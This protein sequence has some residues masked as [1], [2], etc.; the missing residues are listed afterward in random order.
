[1]TD[2]ETNNCTGG[3]SST[4]DLNVIHDVDLS[5][6]STFGFSQNTAHFLE[7]CNEQ[8][9]VKAV[10]L[11]QDRGWPILVVGDGSNIVF[12]HDFPGLI[13]RQTSKYI[14][15]SGESAYGETHVTAS[16]GVNWN[17]LVKDT[18]DRGYVGLENLSLIPGQ[19]GAAPVQNIG[20]YGVELC[21]RMVSLRAFHLPSGCWRTMSPSDCQFSYRNSLFKTQNQDYIIAEV[22]FR[23]GAHLGLQTGYGALANYLEENHPGEQPNAGMVSKAVCA[24]RRAKLPDP[25][26]LPNAGSFFHNP[27]IPEDHYCRLRKRYPDLVGYKQSDGLYKLAAGWLIDKLGY[28]GF[29]KNGVGVHA[30]QALVL[31]KYQTAQASALIDLAQQI[32]QHVDDEFGVSLDI[33]PRIV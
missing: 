7:V 28:K 32:R 21:D 2:S 6:Y 29:R 30:Q 22:T 16:A 3:K 18:V 14:H 17:D 8:E 19:V 12:A 1:M 31:I 24:I 15:Y 10:R 20:A 27:V 9:L 25:T 5:P 23:L 13:V 4:D 33:E 26:E 11:A